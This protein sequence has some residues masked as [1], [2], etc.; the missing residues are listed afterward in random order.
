MASGAV[1]EVL[2][3][4]SRVEERRRH[5]LHSGGGLSGRVG[6]VARVGEK[7]Q[8]GLGTHHRSGY[9]VLRVAVF[10]EGQR[11]DLLAD[12]L[13]QHVEPTARTVGARSNSPE[14][15]PLITMVAAR[16]SRPA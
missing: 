4:Q 1:T 2:L 7:R 5:R 3:I 9:R 12:P 16:M 15:I 6:L 10:G 13:E 14:V 8:L 11:A